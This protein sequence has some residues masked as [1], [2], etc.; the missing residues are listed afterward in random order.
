[1]TPVLLCNLM[2]ILCDRYG[3]GSIHCAQREVN[4]VKDSTFLCTMG[5]SDRTYYITLLIQ[6]IPQEGMIV[7]GN[8]PQESTLA[9]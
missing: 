5:T 3:A 7:G 1:M 6:E 9:D 8:V 4:D 2:R